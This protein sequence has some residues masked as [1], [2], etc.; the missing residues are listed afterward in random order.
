[1]HSSQ[2][3]F[4]ICQSYAFVPKPRRSQARKLIDDTAKQGSKIFYGETLGHMLDIKISFCLL[5]LVK[6]QLPP[7]DAKD[8]GGVACNLSAYPLA[9]IARPENAG[10]HQGLIHGEHFGSLKGE[11]EQPTPAT[12]NYRLSLSVGPESIVRRAQSLWSVLGPA[13]LSEK[14]DGQREREIH[15]TLPVGV[16]EC[17]L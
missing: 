13:C 1:M 6:F 15:D 17:R 3:S 9:P 10:I 4:R 5:A 16:R 11:R 14:S 8:S 7:P 12:A 2:S